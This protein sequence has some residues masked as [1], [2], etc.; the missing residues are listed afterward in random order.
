MATCQ[1]A[2]F[3]GSAG[4]RGKTDD[5]TSRVNVRHISLIMLVDFDFASRV[6]FHTGRREVEPITVRLTANGIN[7]RVALY[8]FSAF[9]FCKHAVTLRIDSNSRHFFAETEGRSHLAQMIG[10]I[11]RTRGAL[12]AIG[13]RSAASAD[14]GGSRLTRSLR[15]VR[16]GGWC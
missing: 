6:G 11:D 7:E 5:V 14:A 2:L 12:V 3:H 13:N 8:L 9:E 15:R 4:K 1:P 10:G 16:P